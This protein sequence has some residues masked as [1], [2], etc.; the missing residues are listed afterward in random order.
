MWLGG[1]EDDVIMKEGYGVVPLNP[2]SF[3]GSE[4]KLRISEVKFLTLGK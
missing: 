3:E 1:K 4:L 2:G